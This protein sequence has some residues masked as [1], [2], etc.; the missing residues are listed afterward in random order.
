MKKRILSLLLAA[1]MAF[2]SAPLSAFAA[3]PEAGGQVLAGAD[4]PTSNLVAEGGPASVQ[5]SIMLIEEA[6][7]ADAAGGPAEDRPPN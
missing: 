3:E 7:A 4:G 6:P 2:A 5:D 1:A